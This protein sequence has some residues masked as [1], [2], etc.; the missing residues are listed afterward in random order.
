VA[1]GYIDP[2][3]WATDIAGGSSYGYAL[4]PT[5]A[6]SSL[7]G[8]FLQALALRLGIATGRDLAQLCRERFGRRTGICLWAAAEFGIIAC[9]LAEVIGSAIA[10]QLLFGIPLTLGVCLT[11][12]DVLLV[13]W[14]THRGFRRVEALIL[15]LL[16]LIGGCFAIEIVFSHPQVAALAAAL[17]PSLRI[18]TDPGLLYLAIGI[19]GATVM[20]HNL[21]LHSS[22]AQ[23]RSYD[24]GERGKREAIRFAG[25]DSAVALTAALFINATI[26]IVAAGFQRIGHYDVSEIQDA[27]RLLGPPGLASLLFGVALLASGQTSTLTGTLAGQIVMQGFLRLCISPVARRVITR[28]IAIVPAVIVTA[29]A[30]DSGTAKLLIMSQIVLSL[31]LSFAVVP[32]VMFTN[33]SELMGVFVN[34]GWAR[35]AGWFAAALIAS[36]NGWLVWLMV[37]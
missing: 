35:A 2:G 8:I 37:G 10:L 16:V 28:M 19:L 29:V 17:M 30:G 21:Y 25:F 23:T 24:L 3:N 31:Q 32:L 4:L 18:I 13:L 15:A 1:V 5:I 36:L 14:F 9:D 20:P 27:Y 34:P 22:I 6:I 12:C 11:A 33:D 7:L 26:L